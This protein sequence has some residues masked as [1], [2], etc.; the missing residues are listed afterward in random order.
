MACVVET[1]TFVRQGI[2]G[3]EI[4][5]KKFLLDANETEMSKVGRELRYH[6]NI[7]GMPTRLKEPTEAKPWYTIVTP[8]SK[9]VY[10]EWRF[11]YGD[12]AV[13]NKDG[14]A[15]HEWRTSV[16]NKNGTT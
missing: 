6:L 1:V 9:S 2:E 7:M 5:R 14:F 3:R 8:K 15:A 12:D 13:V 4:A 16:G 10:F 11:C